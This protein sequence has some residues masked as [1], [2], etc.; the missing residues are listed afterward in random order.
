MSNALGRYPTLLEIEMG[1]KLTRKDRDVL[2]KDYQKALRDYN[3]YIS[4]K[5]LSNE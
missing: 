2:E 4:G 5:I 3:D 1:R